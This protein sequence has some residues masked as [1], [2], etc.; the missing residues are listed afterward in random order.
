M[1]IVVFCAMTHL[2]VG[3]MGYLI[4]QARADARATRDLEELRRMM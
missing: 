2:V 1:S 3:L 4:G